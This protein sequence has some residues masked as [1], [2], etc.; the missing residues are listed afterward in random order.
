MPNPQS[1]IQS[2][3][4]IADPDQRFEAMAELDAEIWQGEEPE[5]SHQETQALLQRLADRQDPDCEPIYWSLLINKADHA[6][7][8]FA[9]QTLQEGPEPLRRYAAQYLRIHEPHTLQKHPGQ[10]TERARSRRSLRD[11]PR[12]HGPNFRKSPR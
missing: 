9:I 2:R 11:A 1:R 3:L 8:K 7:S 4:R 12:S 10:R 6:T 5:L